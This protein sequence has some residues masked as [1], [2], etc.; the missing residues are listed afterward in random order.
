MALKA[1]LLGSG[2]VGEK[3]RSYGSGKGGEERDKSDKGR[4]V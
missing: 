3:K 4:K 2:E 1:S